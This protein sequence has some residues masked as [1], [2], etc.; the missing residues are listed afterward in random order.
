MKQWFK[1]AVHSLETIKEIVVDL[2]MPPST[3]RLWRIVGKRLVTSAVYEGWRREAHGM[4]YQQ[5][6][7]NRPKPMQRFTIS[8]VLDQR[9]RGISDSDN[10]LKAVLDFCQAA[11]LVTND[12]GCD[13]GTWAWGEAPSGCRIILRGEVHAEKEVGSAARI[14]ANSSL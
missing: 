5:H 12:R 4:F 1:N 7:R 6:A 3:N 2:P 14:A 9:K 11:G 8:I 13:G 10:R